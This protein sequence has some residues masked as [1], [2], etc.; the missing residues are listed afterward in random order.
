MLSRFILLSL[1]RELFVI[2]L[3]SSKIKGP[4]NPGEYEIKMA[5]AKQTISA[6]AVSL[7]NDIKKAAT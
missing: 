4:Y 2:L 6:G 3:K 7:F 5:N 1:R